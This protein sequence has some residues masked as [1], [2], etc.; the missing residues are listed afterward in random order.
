MI[1]IKRTNSNKQSKKYLLPKSKGKQIFKPVFLIN[2]YKGATIYNKLSIS[3]LL[4]A[5]IS[6]FIIG[7]VGIINL[8]NNNA[9]SESIYNED[10][11][12]LSP[13][14]R[15]QTDFITMGTKVNGNDTFGSQND[16]NDLSVKLLKELSQYSETVKDTNEKA[17]LKQMTTDI[18]DYQIQM[19]EVLNCFLSND[20]KSGYDLMKDKVS[21]T[22]DHFDGLITTLFSQKIAEAKQRNEQSQRNFTVSMG[23]MALV[24]LIS[25]VLAAFFGRLNAKLICK[26]ITSLVKTADEISEGNL[27]V[28]IDKGNGDEISIL[29]NA[30]EKMTT[31]W[32]GYINDI[33]SVLFQMSEGNLDVEISSEY[34][35]DFIK[36]KESINHIVKNLNDVIGQIIIA[37]NEVAASSKQLSAGSQSLSAGAT[38]QAA[39]VEQLTA[40]IAEIANKTKENASSASKADKI[41][42]S[43]KKDTE[44][45]NEMMERMLGSMGEISESA[46]GISRII[47]VINDIAFQTNILALNA[48]IEAARAGS[49]G[50]GFAVVAE[51][52]RHLAQ[53]SSEAA[54]DTT[55]MIDK[56]LAKASEG[57]N[58]A[59][60]T[61]AA[62]KM[63]E[64]GVNGTA[65]I[66]DEIARSS[67]DQAAGISQLNKGID[68]VSK[69][70]QNNSATAEQSAAASEELF[71]EAETMRRLV[72]RFKVRQM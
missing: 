47:K 25:I 8:N 2:K 38:E 45:G 36:I 51:E 44:G 72:S 66:I 46:A 68:E 17:I 1:K 37:S 70:V 63:I 39:S 41:A 43:V 60:D 12:P 14:Y 26:P 69:I 49:Y 16:I 20:T 6:S 57:T 61:S 54:K 5:F 62:L 22:S 30:F 13:L 56:S 23:L 24:M 58:I 40:S 21:K 52:V 33:S 50:R 18:T 42:N 27:N 35:G 48:S 67:N 64:D 9:M 3:F 31:A 65:A 11:V 28:T 29:A 7:T 10:L 55:Q 4:I 34:K 59:H 15:I 19:R 71:R 32:S 53:R